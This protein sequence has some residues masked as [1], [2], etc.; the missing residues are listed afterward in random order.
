MVPLQTTSIGKDIFKD[1]DSLSD[2]YLLS[3]NN[4]LTWEDARVE[5]NTTVH[6]ASVRPSWSWAGSLGNNLKE[7]RCG[8][9]ALWDYDADTKTLTISGYGDMSSYTEKVV[10]GNAITSVG[11]SSFA[12]LYNLTEVVFEENSQ[13]QYIH[14]E[15]FAGCSSLTSIEIP[16]SVERLIE[17]AFM[18]CSNLEEV[19]IDKDSSLERI[20]TEAFYLCEKLNGF[21]IPKNVRLIENDAFYG[22]EGMTDI[23]CYANPANK[24]DDRE[25]FYQDDTS[26]S[27]SDF[28]QD[29]PF[30]RFHILQGTAQAYLEYTEGLLVA[31]VE[32]ITEMGDGVDLLGHSISLKGDIGVNFYFELASDILADS[33]SY[34]LFTLADGTTQKV[35]VSEAATDTE[36][37]LHKTCKVFQCDVA[38][39]QMGDTI[40]AQVYM[41]DDTA[42]GEAF[43]YTVYQY[44]DEI[45]TEDSTYSIEARRLVKAMAS[46]GAYSQ[47]YF[48]YPNAAAAAEALDNYHFDIDYEALRNHLNLFGPSSIS[49][50][51]QLAGVSIKLETE[52]NMR[53]W[54][55]NIPAGSKFLL[56][57]AEG[58]VELPA[59]R[60][61]IYTIVTVS[62]IA[63]SDLDKLFMIS[64]IINDEALDTPVCYN[65]MNYCY[66]VINHETDEVYTENLQKLVNALHIYNYFANEYVDG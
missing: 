16:S 63:A 12:G 3:G 61:G 34:V 18:Y 47:V 39:K 2:V 32:D 14:K 27:Y 31:F 48:G 4:N 15:A 9:Y 19:T 40:T 50:P 29:Y 54:F 66:A 44:V 36:T 6:V 1:C 41:G 60:K 59:R 25:Y 37:V 7:D 30:T 26:N 49:A 8:Y 56:Q 23:Y 10:I 22:C 11:R 38:P 64:V 53:L 46:Y 35:L 57:T 28:R 51:S 20:E 17:G 21:V 13:V 45:N 43:S 62:D 42:R 58:P 24:L 55:K 52:V 33:E 5:P 65:P